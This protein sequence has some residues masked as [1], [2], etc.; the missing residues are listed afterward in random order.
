MQSL[1]AALEKH[2]AVYPVDPTSRAPLKP[3]LP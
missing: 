1:T 3:K 2:G